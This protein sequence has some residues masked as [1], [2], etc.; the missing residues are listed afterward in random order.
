MNTENMKQ[1]KILKPEML[2]TVE[3]GNRGVCRYVMS[4]ANGY[5]CRYANGQW[6]Y[7][8]TKTPFQATRDVVVNG[9][10]DIILP[11]IG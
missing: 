8:V 11:C 6:D 4:G 5:S 1:F 3:G 10:G 7:I 9:F 2:A